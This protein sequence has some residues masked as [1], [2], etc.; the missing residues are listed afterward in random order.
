MFS[1]NEIR[2]KRGAH[3]LRK[4]MDCIGNLRTDEGMM[5]KRANGMPVLDL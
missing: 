5:L 4:M 2:S 3:E 1:S